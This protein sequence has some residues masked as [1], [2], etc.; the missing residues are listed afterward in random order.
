MDR[1]VDSSSKCVSCVFYFKAYCWVFFSAGSNSP[2][3]NPTHI[4][5]F[6]VRAYTKNVIKRVLHTECGEKGQIIIHMKKSVMK[7]SIFIV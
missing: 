4:D 5:P 1:S 3:A 7:V 2:K 6:S